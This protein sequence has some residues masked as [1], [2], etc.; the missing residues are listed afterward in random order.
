MSTDQSVCCVELQ[1]AMAARPPDRGSL[2]AAW[3]ACTHALAFSVYSQCIFGYLRVDFRAM[4]PA[5]G[6]SSPVRV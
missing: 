2:C 1:A 4:R 3:A 5:P 6:R